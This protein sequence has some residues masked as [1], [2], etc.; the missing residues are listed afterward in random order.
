MPEGEAPG[1]DW[2]IALACV[3]VF[4]LGLGPG[5]IAEAARRGAQL[6]FT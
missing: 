2:G 6:I 5:T 1:L 4:V 3:L